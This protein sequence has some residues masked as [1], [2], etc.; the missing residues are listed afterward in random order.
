MQNVLISYLL[1]IFDHA[2]VHIVGY[3]RYIDETGEEN[4]A[5]VFVLVAHGTVELRKEGV[6]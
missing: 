5:E 2:M 4:L 3:G 6:A 1:S